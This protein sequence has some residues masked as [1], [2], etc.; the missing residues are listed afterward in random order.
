MT[1][2]E[3]RVLLAQTPLVASVQ[4]SPGSPTADANILLALARASQSEGVR[5]LRL[6]GLEAIETIRAG[7]GLPTIGLIKRV[8]PDSQVYITPTRAEVD[9]LLSSGVEIIA[10]DAT[11]RYRPGGESLSDL[12]SQVKAAGRL[13]MADC[14]SVASAMLAEQLGADILST[15]LAG[16]TEES[17][18]LTGGPALDLVREIASRTSL[19]VLA[20]G[21][22]AE[23]RQAAAALR[24]GASGVVIGGAINDPI[25]QTR[26]FLGVTQP[27]TQHV[28][29][30]DLGGTW[31]RAARFTPSW[32]M[33]DLEQ[34]PID[35]DPAKRCAWIEAQAARWS[36]ETIGISTGGTVDPV[37]TLVV[38]A[39]PIIPDHE[40]TNFQE[41]L[42]GRKVRALNDGLATAWGHANLP[43]YAG[44]SV[45]TLALGTG[46]GCGVVREGR[47]LMGPRGEYPRLNDLSTATGRSFEDLLGGAALTP[48][49]TETQI[50]DALEAAHSAEDILRAMYHPYAIVRCGGVGLADWM[51]INADPTP[52]GPHAGL[53]GA[54]ALVLFPSWTLP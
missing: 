22:Y 49:P 20:E 11:L 9:A 46:V 10:L 3:F 30:I 39:K 5:F 40:G 16:Y 21:R 8:Y 33:I 23:P 26:A 41:A 25:K 37:T 7:T 43:Q 24:A 28:L 34:E 45:V 32:E 44:K 14:D 1:L 4:A 17:Q 27:V 29:A 2:S 35:A 51:E 54:A 50:L 18:H 12:I 13:V 36:C 19:P 53:Y 42:P 52:F 47:I 15:T 6:E 48:Q 38:E 31:M